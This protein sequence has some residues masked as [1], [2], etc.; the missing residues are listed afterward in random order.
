MT[1]HK[2]PAMSHAPPSLATA[3][4]GKARLL[5]CKAHVAIHP[6]AFKRDN[7]PGYLGLV[8]VD[9]ESPSPKEGVAGEGLLVTWVPE[10][11]LARMDAEDREGYRRA[12]EMA[13]GDREEDGAC[14]R[15]RRRGMLTPSRVCVCVGPPAKGGAVCILRPSHRHLQHPPLSRACFSCPQTHR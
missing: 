3:P 6:T 10:Q 14:A 15:G 9:G 8:D 11:V 5:Y 12:G 7:I 2:R 1:A 13:E 4:P